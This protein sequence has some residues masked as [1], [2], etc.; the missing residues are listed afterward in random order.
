MLYDKI[1]NIAEQKN[2]SIYR[3]EKDLDLSNGSIR[4][5]NSSIPLSQTLKKVADYLNVSIDKLMEE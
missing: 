3:I 5:W 1:K 2:I 4:K